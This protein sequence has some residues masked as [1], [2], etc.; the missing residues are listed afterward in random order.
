M[1]RDV[2]TSYRW[3]WE[4]EL[5]WLFLWN[6]K[7]TSRRAD[8]IWVFMIP[9][10][11]LVSVNERTE[12]E[13]LVTNSMRRCNSCSCVIRFFLVRLNSSVVEGIPLSRRFRSECKV[14]T[15]QVFQTASENMS[16]L[17]FESVLNFARC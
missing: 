16:V 3:F 4:F 1:C 8:G 17:C 10:D 14:Q 15:I 12:F 5:W 6:W 7:H 9:G 2:E 11:A 13:N